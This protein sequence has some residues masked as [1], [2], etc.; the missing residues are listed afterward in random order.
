ML[1]VR[2]L[3]IDMHSFAE[4]GKSPAGNY[5]IGFMTP[6]AE[7]SFGKVNNLK[8]VRGGILKWREGL[9]TENIKYIEYPLRSCPKHPLIL[10]VHRSVET[11]LPWKIDCFV[12]CPQT[13]KH[14]VGFIMT[15]ENPFIREGYLDVID[16]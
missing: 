14:F 3:L 13:G 4:T 16:S 9:T 10:T 15:N 6:D 1:E 8:E 2:N 5:F 12:L 7:L 11:F